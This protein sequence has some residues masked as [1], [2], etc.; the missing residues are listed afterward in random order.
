MKAKQPS[1]PEKVDAYMK[2]L[3]HP[4]GSVVEALRQVILSTDREIGRDQVERSLLLLFR[5]DE[6]LRAKGVQAI[7]DRVQSLSKGLY[8][9]GVSQ[10]G[11]G[12]RQIG[13]S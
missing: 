12:K 9:P 11:S 1:E 3:K 6:I 4:L 7:P 2:R 8:S 13:T 10:W 5:R